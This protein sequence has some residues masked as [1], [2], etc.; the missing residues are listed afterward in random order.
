MFTVPLLVAWGGFAYLQGDTQESLRKE[1]RALC[2]LG[3]KAALVKG[4]HLAGAACDVL[5][6]EGDFDRMSQLPPQVIGRADFDLTILYPDIHR[7]LG[8]APNN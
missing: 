5:L 4:G 6:A 8:P 3:A 1:V 2:D 7:R